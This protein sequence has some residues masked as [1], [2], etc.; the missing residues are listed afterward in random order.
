MAAA[1]PGPQLAGLQERV[2]ELIGRLP[3]ARPTEGATRHIT[4]KFL[5]PTPAGRLPDVIGCC[6][7]AAVGGDPCELRIQGLGAFPRA[8]RATVL[9]AG[10][11]DPAGLL[12]RLADGLDRAFTPMGYRAETRPFAAHVT[13]ARFRQPARLELP[14]LEPLEPFVLKQIGLYRSHLSPAGARYEP[15][16]TFPLG[17]G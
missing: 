6:R 2:G 13:L 3:G 17:R 15:L 16:A 7:D 12:G 14:D 4:I 5:G 1:V 11:T 10:V 8:A 9:W